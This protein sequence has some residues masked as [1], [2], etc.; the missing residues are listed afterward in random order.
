MPINIIPFSSDITV[1]QGR[2]S[3]ISGVKNRLGRADGIN[4]RLPD[5]SSDAVNDS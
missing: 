3:V 4:L 2:F 1:S 5:T